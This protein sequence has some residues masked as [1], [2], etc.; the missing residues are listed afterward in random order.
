MT[1]NFTSAIWYRRN[2]LIHTCKCMSIAGDQDC[3]LKVK[4]YYDGKR[5]VDSSSYFKVQL[6]INK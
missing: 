4:C 1:M 3:L 2:K 6:I 5:H